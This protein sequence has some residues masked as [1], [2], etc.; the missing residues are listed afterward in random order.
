MVEYTEVFD[1]NYQGES[2]KIDQ[3]DQ[4]YEL[5]NGVLK[6]AY[7][8]F[9]DGTEID[10]NGDV[11]KVNR[12][13]QLADLIVKSDYMPKAI[14]NRMWS[15]FFGYG[16][17]KPIDD[18]GPHN[19][20]THPELLDYLAKEF[21]YHN[22]DLKQLV[23]WM[24]LSEPYSLAAKFNDSNRQDDPMLGEKPAFSHFYLRQMRA[25]ELY[26]SLLACTEADKATTDENARQKEQEG[27][28]QQF[29]IAFG[30]DENDDTTTFN[31]TIPQAL[32]MMN[33]DLIKKATDVSNGSFLSKI[34]NSTRQP[35]DKINA[36]YWAAL[37]RRPSTAEL[38]RAQETL[39]K[40][41]GDVSA[42]LQDV[43]WAVLNSN[44][45]IIQH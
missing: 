25:E 2:K 6:V 12:R 13:Q 19:P 39:D 42:A 1:T 7:P 44:E 41:K 24:V 4:F 26:E 15:H 16:F 45:F 14:V 5:R 37:A 22:C 28:L 27:W 32:M 20:P 40:R 35:G 33:G 30:T 10:K 3:A 18:M 36:I 31:G 8:V 21:R 38:K 11:K 34:A 17:T 43:F 29:T 23:R 9:V